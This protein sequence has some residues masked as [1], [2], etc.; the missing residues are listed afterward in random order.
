MVGGEKFQVHWFGRCKRAI[1]GLSGA[2]GNWLRPGGAMAGDTSDATADRVVGPLREARLP[3]YDGLRRIQVAASA[4][5]G[6][7]LPIAMAA[8][9]AAMEF[10][11]DTLLRYCHAEEFT[12]FIAIDGVIGVTG[13]S[14]VMVAQ[15]RSITAMVN[16]LGQVAEAARNAGD[17]AAYRSYFLPLLHGIY[18]LTRAHLESEDD[19]Y[20]ALLDEHL[21]ESQV[22]VVV[23]NMK[24]MVAGSAPPTEG[25][26]FPQ[27]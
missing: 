15:H 14:D 25:I 27:L 24:R 2:Q 9:D 26:A 20:L 18:A 21:S 16:D 19:A 3:L 17:V 4:V 8:L 7:E 1:V 11:V 23:D 6:A 12:M 10:L 13:A 22:G 5:D